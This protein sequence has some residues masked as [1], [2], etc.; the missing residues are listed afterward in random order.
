MLEKSQPIHWMI[1]LFIMKYYYLNTSL[2]KQ[3]LIEE[4]N[5]HIPNEGKKPSLLNLDILK[6]VKARTILQQSFLKQIIEKKLLNLV[7]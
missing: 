5:T 2:S 3:Q 6:I 1:G 7:N 4:L